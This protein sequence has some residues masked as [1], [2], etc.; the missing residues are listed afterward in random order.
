[1]RLGEGSGTPIA[2]DIIKFACAIMNNMA[3]FTEANIDNDYIKKL[4]RI[5]S[6]KIK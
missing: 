4:D 6:Y 1:M 5:E 3:T 2:F